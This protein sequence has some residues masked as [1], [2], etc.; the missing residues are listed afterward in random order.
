MINPNIFFLNG[1]P[2]KKE[3]KKR[4]KKKKELVTSNQMKTMVLTSVRL[5]EAH[6]R[7]LLWAVLQDRMKHLHVVRISSIGQLVK[8]HEF[9]H[10][11]Q[12]ISVCIQK[13][14]ATQPSTTQTSEYNKTLTQRTPGRARLTG[15][16]ACND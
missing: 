10:G 7:G 15:H 8:D 13:L 11:A 14:P 1:T 12:V 16:T 3:R 4:K 9:N 2:K 6:L 5:Y